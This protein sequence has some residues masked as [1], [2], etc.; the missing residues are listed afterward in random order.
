MHNWEHEDTVMF[1]LLMGFVV[2]AFLVALAMFV[3]RGFSV[4]TST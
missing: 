3:V 4:T 2:V 1:A